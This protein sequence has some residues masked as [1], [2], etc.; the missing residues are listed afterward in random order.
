MQSGKLPG[1]VNLEPSLKREGAI[2][3]ANSSWE[4]F[5]GEGAVREIKALSILWELTI[6]WLWEGKGQY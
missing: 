2:Y 5:P 4:E 3:Q 1:E 6:I